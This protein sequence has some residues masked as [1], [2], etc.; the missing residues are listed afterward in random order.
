MRHVRLDKF[1]AGTMLALIVAT[2]RV[3]AAAPDAIRQ[4]APPP[5]SL[6]GQSLRRDDATPAQQHTN[7]VQQPVAREPA[8]PEPLAQTPIAPE[9]AASINASAPSTAPLEKTLAADDSQIA[10]RLR[11]QVKKFDKRIDNLAERKALESYYTARQFAPIFGSIAPLDL[12]FQPPF[13]RFW[14]SQSLG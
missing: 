13:Q 12:R 1:L 14:F 10:D 2:P 7:D 11:D 8:K 6:N 3:S 4:I 9:P 5:P